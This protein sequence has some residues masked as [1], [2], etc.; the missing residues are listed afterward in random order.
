MNFRCAKIIWTKS[1][2]GSTNFVVTSQEDGQI[3][4]F[5]CNELPGSGKKG[6]Q[7]H[8]FVS[9]PAKG[10]CASRFQLNLVAASVSNDEVIRKS[11]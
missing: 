5:N 11:Y 3:E 8:N 10:L 1:Y 2:D 6:L 4:A 9:K 7:I